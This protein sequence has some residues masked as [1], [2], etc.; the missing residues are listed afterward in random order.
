M[1]TCFGQLLPPALIHAF[2]KKAMHS[3]FHHGF[4]G[5]PVLSRLASPVGAFHVED[6]K[7]LFERLWREF[8]IQPFQHGP[9]DFTHPFKRTLVLSPTTARVPE[10]VHLVAIVDGASLHSSLDDLMRACLSHA[11]AILQNAAIQ[12]ECAQPVTEE[13]NE[14]TYANMPFD[15]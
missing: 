9:H 1:T 14:L 8:C 3:T 2:T 7:A 13:K 6:A 11:R 10:V 12:E 4:V 5:G 15:A